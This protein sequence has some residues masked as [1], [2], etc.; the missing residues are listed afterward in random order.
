MPGLLNRCGMD[1]SSHD[2]SDK[3]GNVKNN[4]DCSDKVLNYADDLSEED[5][6]D[7]NL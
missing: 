3:F 6:Y 5:N 7:E 2:K 1:D 4:E